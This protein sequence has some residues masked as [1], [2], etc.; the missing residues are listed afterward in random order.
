[1]IDYQYN[2]WGWMT[3]IN[4]DQMLLPDPA[5]FS[6]KDVLP[7]YKGNI[8][9][10]DWRAVETIGQNPS[11]TPKRYGYAYDRLNRLTAG[12]YQNPNNP[13][14]KENTESLGYD[15][16]GNITSLYRTSVTEYGSTIPT[17]ID[18]LE[19]IYAVQNKSNRLT[20]I[21]DFANNYT[22]YEGGGQ[23]IKYDVNG[24]MTEMPDKGISKIRY[25]HL[26]LPDRKSVV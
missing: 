5:L 7:K 1:M 19:Y 13:N 22:G 2:I 3:H 26:N 14:S 17:K 4:K 12:Y 8:A 11:S 15:L 23:E 25:N 6:G 18:D 24:N 21:H 16:N 10:V 20:N 9:E